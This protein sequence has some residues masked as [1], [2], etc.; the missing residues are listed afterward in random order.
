MAMKQSIPTDPASAAAS[1]GALPCKPPAQA[2][3]TSVETKKA[4]V[5]L[6]MDYSQ[7]RASLHDLLTPICTMVSD[8]KEGHD[9]VIM[10][11]GFGPASKD[12]LGPVAGWP[13]AGVFKIV[14]HERAEDDPFVRLACTEAGASMVTNNAEHVAQAVAKVS[15]SIIEQGRITCFICGRTGLSK[16]GFC[17]HL[18]TYHIN[19]PNVPAVVCMAKQDPMVASYLLNYIPT[20]FFICLL[21]YGMIP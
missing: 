21:E 3:G 5:L 2:A 16:L 11:L 1:A 20:L 18:P 10:G 7:A 6:A 19:E 8:R 14:W 17:I 4:R 9:V 15:Q 13:H 12:S